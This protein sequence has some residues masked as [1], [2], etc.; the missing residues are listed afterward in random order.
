MDERRRTRPIPPEAPARPDAALPRRPA[1]SRDVQNCPGAACD[2][3]Q[4]EKRKEEKGKRKRKE[5]SEME[6]TG[7]EKNGE[8]KLKKGKGGGIL[9]NRLFSELCI[10]ELT[11]KAIRE[12]NYTHL[13]KVMLPP[14]KILPLRH[15]FGKIYMFLFSVQVQVLHNCM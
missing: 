14:D 15:L 8:E 3:P 2:E 6:G 5:D 11:A 4:K 12:M 10:S 1:T 13:T 9:T 7:K